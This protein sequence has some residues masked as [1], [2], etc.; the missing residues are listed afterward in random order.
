MKNQKRLSLQQWAVRESGGRIKAYQSCGRTIDRLPTGAYTCSRDCH[1]KPEFL[2]R[3]LT[4]D[5]L[6]IFS[7]GLTE[8]IVS[9]IDEFWALGA[10]FGRYGFLHRRGY[11][12]YGKQGGGKTSL[13]RRI[14]SRVVENDNMTLFCDYPPD[15]VRCVADFR[16][17]EPDRPLVCIFEDV[18]AIISNYGD[19]ALLQC[20]DG[21]LQVNKVVN[22][23]TTNYPERLD[24]RIIARPRRFDR[25]IHVPQPGPEVRE[26]YFARKLPDLNSEERQRWVELSEGFTFAAMSEMV[27]GVFCLKNTLEATTERLRRLDVH[28]PSTSEFEQAILG[29]GQDQSE[30]P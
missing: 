7:G 17:V 11:L 30:A 18:D 6:L 26:A 23:A 24:P 15:F 2:P 20:L 28:K 12:F 16:A 27:V 1:G 29:N 3:D 8:E 9:E 13:I 4:S 19:N 21:S 22:I 5:E 14:V 25:V 10:E